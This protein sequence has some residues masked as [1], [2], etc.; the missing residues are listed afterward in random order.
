MLK[1]SENVKNSNVENIW[2][3]SYFLPAEL[4][5]CFGAQSVKYDIETFNKRE[6]YSNFK[7]FISDK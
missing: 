6:G 4:S 1:F 3:R 2:I 7:A 5:A